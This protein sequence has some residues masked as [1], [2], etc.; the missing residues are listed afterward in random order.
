LVVIAI[1]G[2]P[3]TGKSELA[4]LFGKNGFCVIHLSRFVIENMLYQGYDKRR[5]AYIIDEERL[6]GKLKD[7][8]SKYKD[9]VIEGVGA[10]AIP[11]KLVDICIVL[12]CEPFMLER[13]LTERGFPYEKIQENLEAERF[14]I[15]LG[16]A[17]SNY[18][19]SKVMVFDTTYTSIEEL[20]RVVV[21]ELRRRGI[22]IRNT[23]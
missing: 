4:K 10:E 3:G 23:P 8:L 17:I 11:S 19:R 14:G 9:V 1:C 20:Y 21:D 22:K 18:G 12:T 5:G 16:E 7:I 13:R 2:T 15:I 6:V